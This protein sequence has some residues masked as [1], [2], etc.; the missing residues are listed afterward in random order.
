MKKNILLLTL[1]AFLISCS[2]TKNYSGEKNSDA[3]LQ[4][5]VQVLNKNQEDETARQ[6][7]PVLYADVQHAHLA[8][9]KKFK[10]KNK[11]RSP[12]WMDI[13]S[14]YQ[15]LQNAYSS[16]TRSVAAHTIVAPVNYE[17]S[18]TK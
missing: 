4:N 7:L 11:D 18:I 10:A 12:Y 17:L 2:S 14:E 5:T 8:N 3:A 16:I 6:A 1:L 13:I 9:I 15:S